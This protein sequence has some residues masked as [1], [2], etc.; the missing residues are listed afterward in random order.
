MTDVIEFQNKSTITNL[1]QYLDTEDQQAV[2]SIKDELFDNW[3]KKQIFRTDTEMRVSVLNDAKHPTQA[4]KYWQSVREMSAMFDALMNL[5][6]DIRKNEVERLRLEKAVKEVNDS[7]NPDELQLMELQIDL[8]RNIFDRIVMLQVAHD[9]IREL[10][11]WSRIKAELNDG[12]FDTQDVNTHQAESLH[13]YFANR[14][15]SLNGSSAPGEI[16]NAVGP[17]QSLSRMKK[18]DGTIA[19]FEEVVKQLK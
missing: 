8:D 1:I 11:N 15:N 14:V 16:I 13:K 9:R 3:K 10:Q 5:T 17:F 6:F 19:S 4:S 7:E 12:T 18:P 2:L